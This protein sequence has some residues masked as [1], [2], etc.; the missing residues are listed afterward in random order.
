MSG[1]GVVGGLGLGVAVE[2]SLLVV[3]GCWL[4]GGWWWLLY[5][6]LLSD[7]ALSEPNG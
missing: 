4:W 3:C 7:V 1:W 6:I 5:C 2:L